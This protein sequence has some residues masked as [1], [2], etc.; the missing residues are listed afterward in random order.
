MLQ[1]HL[2]PPARWRLPAAVLFLL[3]IFPVPWAGAQGNLE[4]PGNNSFYSGIG[5]VSG[6]KC[7]ATGPLT[8]RFNGGTPVPLVYGSE[9]GDTASVCGDTA[10][11]FVII[12]NWALLGDGTHTAV[13]YDNGVE[14]GRNTFDVATT[15]ADFLRGAAGECQIAGFPAPGEHAT[16]RW[17]QHTQHPELIQVT[18]GPGSLLGGRVYWTESQWDPTTKTFPGRVHWARLDHS[19]AGSFAI[20]DTRH[21]PHPPAHRSSVVSSRTPWEASCTS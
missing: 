8:V 19:D 5:V 20:P 3:L 13:V 18:A 21:P 4:N 6:W 2:S 14:F 9:R 15:G 17:N 10:N 12:Q 16:F 7:T 11:G 1:T